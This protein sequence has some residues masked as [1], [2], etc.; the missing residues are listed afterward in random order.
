MIVLDSAGKQI[1]QLGYM[2]G[3]PE[4]FIAALNKLKK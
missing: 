2:E 3:S 4:A 1:G